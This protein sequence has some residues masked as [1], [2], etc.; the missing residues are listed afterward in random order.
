MFGNSPVF[1][2]RSLRDFEDTAPWWQ[3]LVGS[4]LS[5]LAGTFLWEMALGRVLLSTVLGAFVWPCGV[6]PGPSELIGAGSS[7]GSWWVPW[8]GDIP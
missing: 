1:S 7:W 5:P 8:G 6:V 3:F 4:P 2:C